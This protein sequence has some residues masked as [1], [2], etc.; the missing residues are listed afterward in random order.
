MKFVIA[1]VL[2]SL[3]AV[4][5]CQTST[6]IACVVNAVNGDFDLAI[7]FAR[8]CATFDYEVRTQFICH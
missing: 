4:C 2:A 1:A 7:A 5:N 8:D 6:D 3:L